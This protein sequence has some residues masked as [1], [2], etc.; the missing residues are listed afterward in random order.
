MAMNRPSLLVSNNATPDLP[1]GFLDRGRLE[2]SS[3][4]VTPED[5]GKA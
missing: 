3:F 5:E 2:N 4:D 1:P